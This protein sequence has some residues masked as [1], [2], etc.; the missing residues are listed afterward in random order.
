MNI[1]QTY[2]KIKE[3]LTKAGIDS[4]AFDTLCLIEKVFG[5]NRTSM[6]VHNKDVVSDE[7]LLEIE[8]FAQ[9]R[10]NFEPLQY[11]LGKWNFMGIDFFVGDGVLIPRD[12]TEVVTEL[13]LEFLKNKQ[14]SN[15]IDLCAGSGAISL[16][17]EKYAKSSV[18]AVELSKK[19][20]EYLEKNIEFNKSYVKA[21]NED[22]FEYVKKIEDSYFDLVV[23]NPPYIKTDDIE[24]LQE[25]VKKEPKMALDGG[26]SGYY[27]Y[28]KIIP[29][30]KNKIK[31]G[32]AI[33]FELGENQ[34]DYVKKLLQEND[35]KNIKYSK[36]LGEVKRAI[37]GYK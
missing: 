22:I 2:R 28:E 15:V 33:A 25:E 30:W 21:I 12:D 16:A 6:I 5:Y 1:E 29:L 26:K 23:S 20:F 34:F 36:D 11:I 8:N 10:V 9:R 7:K 35:F 4:P 24:T 3:D 14:N 17:I 13:C 31:S 19:A 18:M 27:F 37:I 32:G